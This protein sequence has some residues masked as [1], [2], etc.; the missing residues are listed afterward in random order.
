[1]KDSHKQGTVTRGQR[2]KIQNGQMGDKKFEDDGGAGVKHLQRGPDCTLE[3]YMSE[4][5][6]EVITELRVWTRHGGS[7]KSV[8]C[9]EL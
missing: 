3:V 6:E 9:Q 1:M 7:S 4:E 5:S 2:E 8:S